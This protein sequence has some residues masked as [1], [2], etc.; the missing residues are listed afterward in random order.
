M[1]LC[2][3][4]GCGKKAISRGMCPGHHSAFYR[5]AKKEGLI[6]ER[7]KRMPDEERLRRAREAAKAKRE[8]L[9]EEHEKEDLVSRVSDLL[10]R[11]W[12]GLGA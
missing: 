12:R 1:K 6:L 4:K 8:R 9:R 5:K 7:K 2:S 10:K 3:E 11:P